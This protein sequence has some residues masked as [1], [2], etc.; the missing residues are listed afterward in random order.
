[1]E[2]GP[3]APRKWFGFTKY[4][5]FE[6]PADEEPL[7]VDDALIRTNNCPFFALFPFEG[8]IRIRKISREADRHFLMPLTTRFTLPTLRQTDLAHCRIATPPIDCA[9]I[10]A[11]HSRGPVVCTLVPSALTATVTGMSTTSNS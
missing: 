10:R 8:H 1:M 11:D 2:G 5:N 6:N 7:I 3:K 9:A 4:W